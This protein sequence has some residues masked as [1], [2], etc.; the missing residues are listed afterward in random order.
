MKG[1]LTPSGG[2]SNS[3]K[4]NYTDRPKTIPCGQ[5]IGCRL[6]YARMWS[7]RM[8]HENKMHNESCFL[9]LTYNDDTVPLG[10]TLVKEDVQDFIKKLRKKTKKKLRY[11]ACG[12]YGD[13]TER[14]HY[15]LIIFGFFPEDSNKYK[16]TKDGQLWTSEKTAQI[17]GKGFTVHGIVNAD[18]AAYTA[19]YVVKKITGKKAL[20]H[21]N[22]RLPEFSLM[23]KKPGIGAKFY[24]KFRDEIWRNDSVVINSY[25]INP[26]RYYVDKLKKEDPKQWAQRKLKNQLAQNK[27][28]LDNTEDR[29]KVKHVVAIKKRQTFQKSI[30]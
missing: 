9:T 26:P 30:I 4:G 5:C 12:E 13:K 18:T 23:S 2:W 14:P 19:R 7:A 25:E 20:A 6:D 15:H 16:K 10:N 11:Y 29:L 28:I 24:E 27:N 3:P 8:L 1:Y 17:W 21:Y 22:G